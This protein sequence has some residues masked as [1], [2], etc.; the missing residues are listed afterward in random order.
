MSKLTKEN[1]RSFLPAVTVGDEATAEK[2]VAVSDSA[3]DFL[4]VILE[5]CPDNDDRDQAFQAVKLARMY[6]NES[7]LAGPF[8]QI[9]DVDATVAER[10]LVPS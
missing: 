6:A 8:G 1:L 4:V 7:I 3:F 5:Q 2:L 9:N 10:P